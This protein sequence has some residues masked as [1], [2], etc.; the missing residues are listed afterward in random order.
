MN[1]NNIR[2]LTYKNLYIY[3]HEGTLQSYLYQQI[4]Q[5][6]KMIC[7]SVRGKT[8]LKYQNKKKIVGNDQEKV[9]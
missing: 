3:I 4:K 5:N 6:P 2:L 7:F 8:T 9:G 1:K